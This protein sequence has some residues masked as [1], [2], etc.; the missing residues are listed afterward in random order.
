MSLIHS[1][2]SLCF[3]LQMMAKKIPQA[4]LVFS[5]HDQSEIICLFLHPYGYKVKYPYDT[6]GHMPTTALVPSQEEFSLAR[7]GGP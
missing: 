6:L 4:Y 5:V 3:A 1:I 2:S 7:R